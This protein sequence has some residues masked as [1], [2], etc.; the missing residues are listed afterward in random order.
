ME[1]NIILSNFFVMKG[2][3]L[4][5]IQLEWTWMTWI[6]KCRYWSSDFAVYYDILWQITLGQ[7]PSSSPKV[8]EIMKTCAIS[9]AHGFSP[10]Y[11]HHGTSFKVTITIRFYPSSPIRFY[12]SS[13][14]R[15]Y[16]SIVST[17]REDGYNFW[18]SLRV[19]MRKKFK[20]DPLFSAKKLR[21]IF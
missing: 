7:I 18:K 6:N 20:I 15:F 9:P 3:L 11:R 14:I 1:C 19:K 8:P 2:C 17:A 21:C 12:P 16:L 5:V 4:G 13:P 10:K